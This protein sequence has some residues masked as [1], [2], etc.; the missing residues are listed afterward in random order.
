MFRTNRD[1]PLTEYQKNEL[2]DFVTGTMNHVL[3]AGQTIQLIE[4]YDL[5][6]RVVLQEESFVGAIYALSDCRIDAS[7]LVDFPEKPL[8]VGT[9]DYYNVQD[10]EYELDQQSLD[11]MDGQSREALILVSGLFLAF[12]TE[13][14]AQPGEL[15][16]DEQQRIL[17]VLKTC[18]Q[19]TYVDREPGYGT[20]EE[21]DTLIMTTP[22]DNGMSLALFE[23]SECVMQLGTPVELP[24][25]PLYV[26]VL[27]HR[28]GFTG[29]AN[30]E[31]QGTKHEQVAQY[32]H[33]CLVQ[34]LRTA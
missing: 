2:I 25:N 15:S 18:L 1:R 19:Q 8:F 29:N 31:I 33:M 12:K 17:P 34:S 28:E 23:L 21:F 3:E 32:I 10:H 26:G 4:E 27:D 7:G 6:I 14:A 9:R 24:M 5:L 22:M 13:A 16:E 11:R 20:L 30:S